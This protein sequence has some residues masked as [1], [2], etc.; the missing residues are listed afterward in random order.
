MLKID[1][2][3]PEQFSNLI[4]RIWIAENLEKEVELIIP[5]NQYVT[6][7]L[8]LN[9]SGYK[10]NQKWV[11]TSQI[12]G[13]STENTVL[14]YPAGTKLIGVRFF[15]FGLYPFIQMQGKDIINNSLHWSFEIEST[16]KFTDGSLE[17]FNANIINS[18]LTHLKSLI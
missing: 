11:N 8:P 1:T 13:V 16:K 2:Y 7:I 9:F 3:K 4:E 6:L 17:Y 18:T 10:R 5:P 14:T 12:E 15:A